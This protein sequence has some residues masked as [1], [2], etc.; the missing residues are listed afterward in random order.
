MH[1]TNGNSPAALLA[2]FHAAEGEFFESDGAITPSFEGLLHPDFVLIEP[3]ASPYAGSWHGREGL[4]RFLHA[5]NADWAEQRPLQPPQVL[6]DGDTAV[7]VA[8]LQAR[9]R[10]TGQVIVF[11]VC[12]L[13]RVRA[14]QLAETRVFYWD[15]TE[16]AQ[17]LGRS[18]VPAKGGLCL[19]ELPHHTPRGPRR[20]RATSGFSAPAGTC[21]TEW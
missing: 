10:A 18:P 9:S 1:P 16:M 21:P 13:A 15:N 6:E 5:M 8:T 2:R 14:G 7:A 17:A 19:R 3:P 20:P 12:Q 11:P 4:L